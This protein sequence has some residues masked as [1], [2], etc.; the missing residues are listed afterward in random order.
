MATFKIIPRAKWH[1]RPPDYVNRL[2]TPVSQ[3]FIHHGADEGPV[4]WDEATEEAEQAFMRGTQNFHM[5][6]R[7]FADIGYSFAIMPSG[8]IYEA[9]GWD[10]KGGHT[11]NHNSVS[12]AA[13]FA[14]NF[15]PP[16]KKATLRRPTSI[17]LDAVRWLIAEGRR[18]G[19]ISAE[20]TILGHRDVGAKGGS[21]ACPGDRLYAKMDFIREGDDL[22]TLDEPWDTMLRMWS[23]YAEALKDH[24]QTEKMKVAT[25]RFLE[26]QDRIEEK[27][28]RLLKAAPST[29]PPR[30][31]TT[32]GTAPAP[33]RGSRTRSGSGRAQPP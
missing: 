10:R 21:T 20:A 6:V 31:S 23:Q 22:G 11:F 29:R 14:G 16:F 4:G 28:D 15:H 2:S 12:L 30:G 33:V 5:D 24:H 17:S 19:K 1:P 3:F 26:Q 8:R 18:L 13:E 32:R 25:K 7:G 27:L 9:R